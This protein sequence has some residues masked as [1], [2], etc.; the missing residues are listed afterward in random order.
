MA[1]QRV[2]KYQV[3][4]GIGE[5]ELPQGAQFLH[6][7]WI[8]ENETGDHCYLWCLVDPDRDPIRAAVGW[9]MTGVPLPEPDPDKFAAHCLHIGS[10]RTVDVIRGGLFMGHVFFYGYERR[11]DIIDQAMVF[12]PGDKL[13]PDCSE[14]P[15]EPGLDD[16]GRECQHACHPE[17]A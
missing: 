4:H 15:S 3:P 14:L 1:K 10:F 8:G 16:N 5:I 11:T 2:Y 17:I 6:V 7:E 13:C 12:W 9:S